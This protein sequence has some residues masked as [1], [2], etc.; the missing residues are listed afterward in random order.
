MTRL[1]LAVIGWGRLGKAC[2]EALRDAPELALAGIVRRADALGAASSSPIRGVPCVGHVSEL[3][4][5]DAALLCVR[6]EAA[7]GVAREL[8]QSRVRLVECADLADGALRAHHDEIA[9]LAKRYR[10]GAVVGAGWDPGLL[11]QLQR[12]FELLIPKG[13]SQV[14]RRVG[15]ALH[16]TAAAE[17]VAGVRGALCSELRDPDGGTHRYVYVELS[18]GG[19]LERVRQQIEGDPLFADEPTQ[20]L[21]VDDLAALEQENRGVL[22]ERLGDGVG[23]PH[24]SL[25]LEARLDPIAFTARLML[26]AARSLSPHARGAWRYTP[27]GLVP[28]DGPG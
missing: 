5:I 3:E 24:A 25:I 28:L 7:P 21:P 16:H 23:G 27:C 15:T 18:R 6:S 26:D 19:D 12:L 9:H 8:L 17:N 2:A 4:A 10:V 20:V 22:V 1:R 13:H 14:T 11:P